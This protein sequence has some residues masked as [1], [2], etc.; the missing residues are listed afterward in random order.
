MT[1]ADVH[2]VHIKLFTW[3]HHMYIRTLPLTQKDNIN[4][5]E[6]EKIIYS[7]LLAQTHT[8]CFATN[9]DVSNVFGQSIDEKDLNI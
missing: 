4:I 8:D 3:L 7:Q 2:I 5:G 9:Y 1:A 6:F